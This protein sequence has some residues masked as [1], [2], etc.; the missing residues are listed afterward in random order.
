MLLMGLGFLT[1]AAL[2]VWLCRQ[3]GGGERYANLLLGP[4]FALFGVGNLYA[5]FAGG[6]SLAVWVGL[7]YL[8]IAAVWLVRGVRTVRDD[9]APG[10]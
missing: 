8:A 4:A 6:D 7:G 2:Q 5:A 10:G 3:K 9:G 1:L